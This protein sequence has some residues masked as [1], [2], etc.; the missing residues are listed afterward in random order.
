[1]SKPK[2][3]GTEGWVSSIVTVPNVLSA[4]RI[5]LVPLFVWALLERQTIEPLVI[6]FIAGISDLFDG[7]IARHLHQRSKLGAI[8]DPA[9]DK[10]LMAASYILL[11]LPQVVGP[12]RIPLGLTL[13]VFARD[14]MIVGGVLWAYLT[15]GITPV[16]PTII[17]KLTTA[18]QVGTVF[19]VLLTNHLGKKAGWMV[20]IYGITAALTLASWILYYLRGL[21]ILRERRSSKPV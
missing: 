3:P 6:F 13:I 2:N 21:R 8:L 5:L 19:L 17:G 11:T 20:A 4:F 14:L 12:N 9:G 15:F 16:L 7:F 10:L 18:F 1:M